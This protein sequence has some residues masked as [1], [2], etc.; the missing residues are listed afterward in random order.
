MRKNSYERHPCDSIVREKK[1]WLHV[2]YAVKAMTK[3]VTSAYKS[4]FICQHTCCMYTDTDHHDLDVKIT[5]T[6]EGIVAAVAE[7]EVLHKPIPQGHRSSSIPEAY[8][9]TDMSQL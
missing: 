6:C 4:P 5:I 9:L 3:I 7:I 1:K 2:P 8:S